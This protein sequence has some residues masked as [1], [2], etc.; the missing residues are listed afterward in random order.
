M[1]STFRAMEQDEQIQIENA[2]FASLDRLPP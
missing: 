2:G 1:S